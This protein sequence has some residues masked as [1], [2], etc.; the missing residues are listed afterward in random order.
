MSTTSSSAPL[1]S[2][3]PEPLIQ[4]RITKRLADF[5]WWV[6]I[7][8]LLSAFLL[9]SFATS[10]TYQKIL[11][12]LIEGIRLTLTITLSAFFLSM[13]IG[14]FTAFGQMSKNALV[15]NI[16]TLYVQIVRGIPVLVLIL[17][18]AV[19]L[20]P[21]G[22]D[23]LHNLGTWMAEQ[24]WL[25]A[26]NFLSQLNIR[27]VDFV[28]RGIIA[29]AINY[30]AFSSEIFRSGIQSIEKGQLE[31]SKA[32]GLTWG[33]TMRL[34][35][36][37]QA[38]RRI[39]PPLGN[40]FIAMLKESSLL[41]VLGVGEITQLGK[42]YASASFQYLETYNTVAFLYLSMTLILS[43]GVKYMEKRLKVGEQES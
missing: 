39:L 42:K 3:K 32:L 2:S 28:A 19:V 11:E 18:I 30:G 37:P 16:A 15:R 24:G 20:V 41:S 8:M 5:P 43:M 38:I 7:L 23:L 33:K 27:N 25:P 6:L 40:D 21:L 14:L 35:V 22:V 9:Y 1:S 31:A 13:I 36:L 12:T 29:L 10:Q 26:D 4:E 17:Y 34:V